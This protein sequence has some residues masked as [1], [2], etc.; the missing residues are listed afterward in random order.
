MLRIAEADLESA[1]ALIDTAKGRPETACFLAQQCIEK[2]IK[3]VLISLGIP[4]PLV[5]DAGVLVAKLPQSLTPPKGYDLS[6]LTVFATLLRYREGDSI[7]TKEQIEIVLETA[8]EVLAWCKQ[9][10]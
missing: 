4:V 10:I 6:E 5:H 7:L 2:S 1:K 3:A 8:A 9:K